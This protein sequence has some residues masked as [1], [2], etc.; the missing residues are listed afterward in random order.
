MGS[1][2]WFLDQNHFL[3]FENF[4]VVKI[5]FLKILSL[6]RTTSIGGSGGG[7]DDFYQTKKIFSKTSHPYWS[8]Q[9][10]IR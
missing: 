2:R 9:K 3:N 1:S 8:V 7:S 10:K 5:T 4:L 6:L